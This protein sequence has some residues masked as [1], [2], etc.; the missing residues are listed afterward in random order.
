MAG[1]DRPHN[2]II[3]N[4]AKIS[5]SGVEDVENFDETEI[6]LYTAHGKLSIHGTD[7]RVER[8]SVNDGDLSVEG[9]LDS[10]EYSRSVKQ[11]GGFFA[12][13]FG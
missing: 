12:K 8:L 10:L 6:V 13:L 9:V 5:V 2:V 4:R 7:L 1:D 3:Q 11:G